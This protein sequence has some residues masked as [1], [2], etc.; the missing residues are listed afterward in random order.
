MDNIENLV[1]MLRPLDWLSSVDIKSAYSHIPMSRSC[2]PFLQFRWKNRF[3][4]YNSLPFGIANGPILFVRVTKGIMNYLRRNLIEILFYIDDTLIKNAS[5]EQ[6][7]DDIKMTINVFEKCGFTIN[8]KK[9]VLTPTQC[10]V[11]LGFV[12][13]TVAFTISLTDEKKSDISQIVK[14]ALSSKKVSVRFLGKIIGKLVSVF[15]ACPD[16]PLH[17][18]NLERLKIR[19]LRSNGNNWSGRICLHHDHDCVCELL[20]WRKNILSIKCRHL[21]TKCHNVTMYCDASS[22]GWGSVIGDCQAQGR[23]PEK[24]QELSINSKELL[25][26]YYWLLSHTKLLSHKVV[27]VHSDNTTTVSTISKKGSMN[28][29]RDKYTRKIFA[30]CDKYN[31]CLK[32]CFISGV[33]NRRADFSSRNFAHHN[34]EWSLSEKCMQFIEKRCPF[35]MNMDL[36]A[37]HLNFKFRRYCAWKPDPF[38]FAINCF[39][40]DWSQF[41]SFAFPPFSVILRLL[42]KVEEDKV[43]RLGLV[44]PWW[45]QSTWFLMLVKLM[46]S[47]PVFLPKNTSAELNIPWDC[48]LRHPLSSKMRLIFV[49]LSASCFIKNSFQKELLITLRN[50]LGVKLHSTGTTRTQNGGC[51]FVKRTRKRSLTSQ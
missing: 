11:F 3:F 29:F 5:R 37:S 41:N 16:G 26:V 27:L 2:F 20:W 30:H 40:L 50:T 33:S 39:N 51:S 34:T 15:P 6:L 28:R 43:T 4:F 49:T 48:N 13:D 22:F 38:A 45:P 44:C 12:I 18:R 47:K 19:S 7:L 10:L 35:T 17:Y 1:K 46:S 36:F 23:F 42:K 31:I 21:A 25:A 32:I 9:S 24:L 14:K 8:W